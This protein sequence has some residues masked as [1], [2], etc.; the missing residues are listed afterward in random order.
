MICVHV[1]VDIFY[2]KISAQY[3]LSATTYVIIFLIL[4]ISAIAVLTIIP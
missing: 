3:L 4:H 2:I 1:S